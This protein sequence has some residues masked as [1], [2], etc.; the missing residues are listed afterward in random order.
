MVGN[1]GFWSL[2]KEDTTISYAMLVFFDKGL[3][4]VV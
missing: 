4:E 1:V 3:S 2:K